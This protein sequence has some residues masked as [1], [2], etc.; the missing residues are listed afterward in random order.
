MKIRTKLS[1]FP[2]VISIIMLVISLFFTSY[3]SHS[4]IKKQVENHL[5]TIVQSRANHIKALLSNYKET[6][7]MIA[8]GNAFINIFNDSLDTSLRKQNIEKRILKAI[9]SY[10][11]IERINVLEIFFN[12]NFPVNQLFV[13]LLRFI[14]G[15][16]LLEL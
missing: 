15:K 7:S 6:A 14:W 11:E 13:F 10:P 16:S 2:I 5:W 3:I 1:L 4:I 12:Q 8:T 9:K